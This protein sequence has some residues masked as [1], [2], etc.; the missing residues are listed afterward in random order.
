M[1]TRI[2]VCKDCSGAV[3]CTSRAGCWSDPLSSSPRSP[4]SSLWSIGQHLAWTNAPWQ[5]RSAPATRT[6][7]GPRLRQRCLVVQLIVPLHRHC[8]VHSCFTNLPPC[9]V[10]AVSHGC[11]ILR[12]LPFAL[13][14]CTVSTIFQH[15]VL[16]ISSVDACQLGTLD[17]LLQQ[18]QLKLPMHTV[19]PRCVHAKITNYWMREH[20]S[21][22]FYGLGRRVRDP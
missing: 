1:V 3:D 4:R 10:I 14:W 2:N 12:F 19:L 15:C 18:Q 17:S 13:D 16:D 22:L 11:F 20:F 9:V 6:V 21:K 8:C 7:H 5:T